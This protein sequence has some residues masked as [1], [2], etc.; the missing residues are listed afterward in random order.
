[1]FFGA[2]SMGAP[3]PELLMLREPSLPESPQIRS[4]E[5]DVTAKITHARGA[6]GCR[7][8]D[9]IGEGWR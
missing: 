1:M 8:H 3:C 2:V 7:V 6:I 5:S 4:P 9:G